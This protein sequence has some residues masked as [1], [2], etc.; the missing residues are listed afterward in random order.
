VRKLLLLLGV[1]FFWALPVARAATLTVSLTDGAT[2]SGDVLK[3]DAKGL[4]LRLGDETYTNVTWDHL[5]Q[6]TLKQLAQDPKMAQFTEAF[7]EPPEPAHTAAE[8]ITV[9]PVN[10]LERPAHPSLIAGVVTSPVGLFVL[11]VLYVANLLAAYEVSL[12]TMRSPGEVIGLSAVLPVIG[13]II[14]LVKGEKTASAEELA[15]TEVVTAPSGAGAHPDE[16]IPIVEVTRKVE[17]KKLETQIF[18]RGKFTFNKRFVETKF[19]GFIGEAKG[20]A[21]TYSMEVKTPKEQ[22]KVERIMQVSQADVMLETVQRGQI[23]IL[24]SDILEVKLIPRG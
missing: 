4:M 11:L 15:A 14:Y 1:C 2:V 24:L 21:L 8:D 12:F 19:A 9:K 16:E 10:R 17:E 7:I 20:E 22:L 5:S 18:T 23:T 3:S 6:D 13:P